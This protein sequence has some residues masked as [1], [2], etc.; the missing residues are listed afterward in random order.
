MECRQC[1]ERLSEYLDKELSL[2]EQQ[3]VEAHLVGCSD[4]Q[5][6]MNELNAL[7]EATKFSIESI[8]IPIN[9]T[10]KILLSIQKEKHKIAKTQWLASVLLILFIS[11][12]FLLFTRAFSTIFYLIFTTSTAIWRSLVTLI[13]AASPSI[14]LSVG[15]L[16]LTGISLGAYILKRLVQ[17]FDLNGVFQ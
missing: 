13:T 10:D 16:A 14:M 2:I 9:L 1:M 17:D 8:P 12:V 6:L 7:S 4:C 5:N 11:P 3:N 15:I